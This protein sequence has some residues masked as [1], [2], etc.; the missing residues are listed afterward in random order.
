MRDKNFNRDDYYLRI[1]E[2]VASAGTCVRRNYGAVIVKDNRIV[3]VGYTGSPSGTVN[4]CDTGKCKRQEMNI[5]SGQ[6]YELCKSVHAEQNAIINGNPLQ[7][8]GATLYLCGIDAETNMV[9]PK[10]QPCEMCKR[11]IINAGISTVVSREFDGVVTASNEHSV[12][13]IEDVKSYIK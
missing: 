8:K 5:P 13:K 12:I 6:R 2:V 10:S 7:M 3:S 4:C 11:A 9:L 1:A